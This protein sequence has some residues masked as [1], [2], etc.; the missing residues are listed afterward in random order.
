VPADR[1]W[2]LIVLRAV[3]AAAVALLITFSAD[4]STRLGF[5]A[6]AALA[7]VTGLIVLIGARVGT[8]PRAILV[9]GALLV[10]GGIAAIFL[11]GATVAV[12][13]FLTSALIGVTGIIELVAGLR[14]RGTAAP[15]RDWIFVGALSVVFAA[16]VL[17]VPADFVQNI[18]I[19]DKEVPPLTA[20]V[21]VVGLLGAY[22]AIV[23]V[24]LVIAGLSLKWAPP[25]STPVGSEAP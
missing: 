21:V 10:L 24:Y 7:L 20:S 9:H 22:A 3:T 25:A 19:P 11:S 17:L 8:L 15:A 12:L 2:K 1:L 13:I 6:L 5:T 23:A 14:A 4:H 16:A 18:S